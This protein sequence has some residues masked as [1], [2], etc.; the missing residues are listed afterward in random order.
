VTPATPQTV[1]P[2]QRSNLPRTKS[3]RT[4]TSPSVLAISEEDDILPELLEQGV[5]GAD[6]SLPIFDGLSNDPKDYLIDL[7]TSSME[8]C[9]DVRVYFW[10]VGIT[11]RMIRQGSHEELNFDPPID[12][13]EWD[14]SLVVEGREYLRDSRAEGQG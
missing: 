6:T 12:R 14:S 4:P 13:V 7:D 11:R 1:D 2:A 3:A 8:D 9:P 5:T 10:K